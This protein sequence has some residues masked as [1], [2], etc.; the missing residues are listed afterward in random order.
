M[1][2]PKRA[3]RLYSI[4]GLLI[5]GI[6]IG[7]DDPVTPIPMD[8]GDLTDIAYNPVTQEVTLP[9]YFP[10]LENPE[11]NPLTEEGVRLGRKLFYDPILSSDNSI[12]CA[13]CHQQKHAFT[14]ALATSTGV[15]GMTGK[16]SS[17]SLMNSGF[18]Y[19]GL[20]WDGRETNLESQALVPVE[21]P[22][23]MH[24]MWPNVIKKLQKDPDYPSDFRR[25]FGIENISDISREH[26]TKALAQFQRTL[27]S[28]NSKFDRVKQNK[29]FFTE[30][31][32]EGFS[33]FFDSSPVLPDAECGHCH[34]EPLF[35]TNEYF[36]NGIQE[37]SS[38]SDFTDLGRGE[39]TG[40]KFDNGK[41]RVPTLRN[42]VFTAPYMHDGRFQTLEEV[43]DHY[44]SGGHSFENVDPLVYPLKLSEKE[45]QSLIAFLHTLSD[46][47]ILNNP[48]FSSPF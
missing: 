5:L 47:T 33:M 25:A 4:F 43:M 42:I 8:P 6:V 32:Y 3:I 12:S 30:E 40:I 45:K 28:S 21:D 17:M 35:T 38:Y 48:D 23:E 2:S 1:L 20:F 31:E 10:Q 46:S 36:N 15:T 24:E 19:R 41:F 39:F 37:V 7:C 11:D 16:R 26:V 9:A 14:D 27:V 18:Y 22:I 13:S 29:D 34:N 44:S